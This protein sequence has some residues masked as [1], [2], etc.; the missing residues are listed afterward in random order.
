VLDAVLENMRG[1]YWFGID[2][3]KEKWSFH[4]LEETLKRRQAWDL[5]RTKD[6]TKQ[7][8]W[9]LKR[10]E[11]EH[12]QWKERFATMKDVEKRARESEFKERQREIEKFREKV[13]MRR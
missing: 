2:I 3:P 5:E 12:E 9:E 4:D 1:S 10:M 7:L 6:I 13:R 8:E 11:L